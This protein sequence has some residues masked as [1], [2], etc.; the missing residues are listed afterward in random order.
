MKKVLSIIALAAMGA[1]SASAFAGTA[2]AS[3]QATA[4]L[5]SS[6][7]IS[8]T[9]VAFGTFTPTAA[10]TML[11]GSGTITSTC[12]NAVP[13]TLNINAGNGTFAARSMKGS[14]TGNTDVLGY[15]LYTDNTYTNVFG[16][17]STGTKNAALTGTGSAQTTNVYGQ[18]NE[19]QFITPDNYVDNLTV[20]LKY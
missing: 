18:L 12:S 7:T 2:T 15:N 20:T 16:D 1:F 5:T 14:A 17:A 9:N 4:T 8:A 10:S 13:Y 19:S 3:F 6:C 11:N